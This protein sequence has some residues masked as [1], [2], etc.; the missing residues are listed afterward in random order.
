MNDLYIIGNGFDLHHKL[1]TSYRSF[2]LYLQTYYGAIYDQLLEYFGLPHIDKNDKKTDPLWSNLERSLSLLDVDMVYDA[3]SGSLASPGAP[4]FR[5]R[6]W[7]TFSIDM[8]MVVDSLTTNLIKAFHEFI[9]KVDYTVIPREKRLPLDSQALF[10]SFNYTDTLESYYGIS[11]S[12][13]TY[14]HGKAVNSDE[15]ILGHGVDP[16]NFREE[17][18]KPPVGLSDEELERWEV[19]MNDQYDYSF[20]LGKTALQNYFS[21][22]YKDTQAVVRDHMEFFESMENIEQV[23]ILGHSLSDVDLPYFEKIVGS[24]RRAPK[25]TVSY[26]WD[27]DRLAHTETL[28]SLGIP[29]SQILMTKMVA[30]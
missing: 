11:E 12:Q 18:S 13:I 17:P 15:I 22:S 23:F 9:L 2:G 3:Y 5:D 4:D 28:C 29:E 26:L 7:N 16:N 10:L 21:S 20:E 8:E 24:I 19:E 25:C 6:D 30:L 14:I 1:D 27:H